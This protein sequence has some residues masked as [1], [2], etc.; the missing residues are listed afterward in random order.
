MDNHFKMKLQKCLWLNKNYRLWSDK[1]FHRAQIL[2][3][4][5]W[6]PPQ[7]LL[8]GSWSALVLVLIY[9]P[10]LHSWIVFC[11]LHHQWSFPV[12]VITYYHKNED[13]LNMYAAINLY[14][15][16]MILTC[17]KKKKKKPRNQQRNS[18]VLLSRLGK[19]KYKQS[20]PELT[21]QILE[22]NFTDVLN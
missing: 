10:L 3:W 19:W 1:S 14:K 16:M 5:R 18:R 22:V 7:W 2:T 13:K 21:E 17:L 20:W 11:G 6:Q 15:L 9:D 12:P 8:A 4:Q